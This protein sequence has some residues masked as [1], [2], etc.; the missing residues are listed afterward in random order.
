ML[1]HLLRLLNCCLSGLCHFQD[2]G[3]E[4][5]GIK[6]CC[7]CDPPEIELSNFSHKPENYSRR[8]LYTL[9]QST[10]KCTTNVTEAKVA[11]L[12]TSHLPGNCTTPKFQCMTALNQC[13]CTKPVTTRFECTIHVV[14]SNADC[15][16]P[17]STQNFSVDPQIAAMTKPVQAI[18]H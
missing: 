15:S 18:F 6:L 7:H 8:S 11:K 1:L 16:K 10:A 14:K 13:T 2:R 4:N 5:L 9:L 12:H 3:L 17:G